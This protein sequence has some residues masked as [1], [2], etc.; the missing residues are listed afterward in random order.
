MSFLRPMS[1]L[2]SAALRPAA[3]SAAPRAR[4]QLRFA[5]G[6]YGSGDG[7]PAGEKPKEQGK[8]LSENLEHPG[9]PPPKVA[10]GKSSSSPNDD[11]TSTNKAPQTSS[12]SSTSSS[13][14]SSSGKREFSTS[15]RRWADSK[16]PAVKQGQQNKPSPNEVKGAQPKI[17]NE[18]PPASEDESEDVKKHNE[19]MD[20]R[21]E[22]AHEKV[23]NE[24]AAKDKV[25]DKFWK[26]E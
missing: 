11:K 19:E 20:S 12:S 9:P 2:R 8:N 23:S 17:L 26:G 22:Q 5:T 7:N 13:K 1:M 14:G 25:S 18:N 6:D 3:L 21:A 4:L 15:T 16:E 24:D 10:E